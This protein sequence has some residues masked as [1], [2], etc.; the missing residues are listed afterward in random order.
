VTRR[1][2]LIEA[3][4]AEIWGRTVADGV[5]G[6]EFQHFC[7]NGF[8]T[9]PRLLER[10]GYM[11]ECHGGMGHAFGEGWTPGAPHPFPETA[12]KVTDRELLDALVFLDRWRGSPGG[13]LFDATYGVGPLLPD[14]STPMPAPP[15]AGAPSSDPTAR[16]FRRWA[17]CRIRALI[18]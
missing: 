9:A 2:R 15:R 7:E 6:A 1:A 16:A 4:T 11:T 14:R 13:K 8:D 12:P 5:A 3:L 10:L 18:S 17:A